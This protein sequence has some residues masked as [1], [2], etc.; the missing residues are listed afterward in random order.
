M[1]NENTTPV[2]PT[3][4]STNL[5]VEQPTGESPIPEPVQPSGDDTPSVEPVDKGTIEPPPVVDGGEP[6][7]VDAEPPVEPDTPEP[8]E[9][10]VV[11][12]RKVVTP[13][14]ES[15]AEV[16]GEGFD[17]TAGWPYNISSKETNDEL[18]TILA[19]RSLTEEEKMKY[20]GEL[21]GNYVK[22]MKLANPNLDAA[23]LRLI[24][25]SM[26]DVIGS[27]IDNGDLQAA[28]GREAQ[29]KA[30][31]EQKDALQGFI[32]GVGADHVPVIDKLFK[33][34]GPR[35]D[36]FIDFVEN[37]YELGDDLMTSLDADKLDGAEII[38]KLDRAIKDFNKFNNKPAF[39]HLKN[40]TEGDREKHAFAA[41]VKT[42]VGEDS[43]PIWD[44]T[45]T[46]RAYLDKARLYGI[47]GKQYTLSS[48]YR[49]DFER[50]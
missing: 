29:V 6:D 19:E 14:P 35:S 10:E 5:P 46:V 13:S 21:V 11:D 25:E 3:E 47:T 31:E 4:D 40:L 7:T 34:I 50:E 15:I 42:M 23:D 22:V 32:A 43:F 30:T 39:L 41:D 20:K 17:D 49:L 18:A 38:D 9:G 26:A 1:E 8:V 48:N 28:E 36:E 44:G 37:S 33:S 2:E 12:K 24:E 27:V 16:M 45:G